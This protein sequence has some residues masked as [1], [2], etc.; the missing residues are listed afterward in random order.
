MKSLE[1]HIEPL[2]TQNNRIDSHYC[3]EHNAE[4]ANAVS[5]GENVFQLHFP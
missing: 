3:L 1:M 5:Y 4:A 2:Q